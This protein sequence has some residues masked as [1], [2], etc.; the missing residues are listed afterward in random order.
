MKR[1]INILI[2]LLLLIVSLLCCLVACV[3]SRPDKFVQK[4][5]HTDYWAILKKYGD[6]DVSSYVAR[7]KNIYW[8]KTEIAEYI[9]IFGKNQA[10]MYSYDKTSWQY[11]V[12]KEQSEINE[13]RNSLVQTPKDYSDINKLNVDYVTN[14]FTEK[15][16]KKEGKWYEKNTQP[17][18]L[19]VKGKILYYEIN[20]ATLMYVIDYKIQIPK[21]AKQA[22]ANALA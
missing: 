16:E 9:W 2:A 12:I 13:L 6:K 20:S 18:C 1:K 11:K 15:Y 4:I 22:K 5:M 14:N 17:A 8:S 3:P 19:Y 10:E 21:E 7:N